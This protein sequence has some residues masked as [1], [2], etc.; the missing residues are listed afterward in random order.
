MDHHTNVPMPL[1]DWQRLS[2]SDQRWHLYAATLAQLNQAHEAAATLLQ[3]TRRSPRRV[4]DTM[5]TIWVVLPLVLGV[6]YAIWLS[7]R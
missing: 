1:P 7:S 6:V 5:I 3:E 4:I 2:D